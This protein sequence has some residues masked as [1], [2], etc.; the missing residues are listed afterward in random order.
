MLPHEVAF[1]GLM[2]FLSLADP[3]LGNCSVT[4]EVLFRV[5]SKQA[6]TGTIIHSHR[7]PT[8]FPSSQVSSALVPDQCIFSAQLG[9]GTE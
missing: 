4:R 6:L 5:C 8:V 1:L 7:V 3:A 9:L 2:G